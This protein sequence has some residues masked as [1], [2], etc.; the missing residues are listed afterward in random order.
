MI[1]TSFGHLPQPAHLGR[2]GLSLHLRHTTLRC[3]RI[4]VLPPLYKSSSDTAKSVS[5]SSVLCTSPFSALLTASIPPVSYNIFLSGS[6][7][8]S[9]A[10]RIWLNLCCDSASGFLSGWYLIESFL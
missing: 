9:Y 5:R 2:S 3:R 1:F 4:A 10:S 7:K 8:S 6:F